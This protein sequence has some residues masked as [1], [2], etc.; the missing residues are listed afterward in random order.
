MQVRKGYWTLWKRSKYHAVQSRGSADTVE[1][2]EL[3]LEQLENS[4]V[5][6]QVCNSYFRKEFWF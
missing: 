5:Q 2:V 6:E 1:T 4:P 3:N